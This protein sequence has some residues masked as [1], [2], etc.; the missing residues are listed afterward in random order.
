MIIS[1]VT[2]TALIQIEE[3]VF[4]LKCH[5]PE[6][7]KKFKPG[8]FANIRISDHHFPLLR[9][10]FSISDVEGDEISFMVAVHGEGTAQLCNKRPGDQLDIIAPLGN[11]FNIEDDCDLHIILAGGI[12][13]APFPFLTRQLAKGGIVTYVGG[14]TAKDVIT[15]GLGD[16]R[17]ATDDGSA[18]YRGNV[19]QYFK[20]E[21]E[22]YRNFKVKVY[23]C[24]PNAM[25]KAVKQLLET[26]GLDGEISTESAMACGFGICQGCPIE[27]NVDDG[28]YLLIC[29]DGP[30]FNVREVVL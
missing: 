28:R 27:K 11:G 17:I 24:G 3:R 20:S 22:Q 21:L 30:V 18:G 5:S 10:P 26:E 23:A 29:K 14:R 15:Y 12:G 6:L 8:Q 2:L 16:P 7:A 13:A 9:R 25:L 19:V 4:I 1:K